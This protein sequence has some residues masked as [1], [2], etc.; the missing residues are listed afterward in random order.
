MSSNWS[1]E[2]PTTPPLAND[3]ASVATPWAPPNPPVPGPTP[4]LPPPSPRRGTGWRA[5]I[6]VVAIA[7]V[8]FAGFAFGRLTDGSDSSTEAN[9]SAADLPTDPPVG[10]V[11][12][13]PVLAIA[14]AVTPAVVKI[15]AGAG[16]G[17]GTV[18]DP[19]GLI[20]TNAHVVGDSSSVNVTYSD[21]S[22]TQGQV[23]GTDQQVDVAVVRVDPSTVLEVAVLSLDDD[24]QVGQIAVAIGTPFAY[25]QTV[26]AGIVSATDRP[27]VLSGGVSVPMVQTDAAI[28]SGNSGGALVDGQGRLIGMPTVIA[29][30]SGDS[31]GIGFAVPIDLAYAQAQKIVNGQTLEMP[32]LGVTG[33][34]VDDAR[35]PGAPISEVEQGSAASDAGLQPGDIVQAVDGRVT[36]S[37]GE[38]TRYVRT[39]SPGDAVE[40]E[41]ERDGSTLTVTA[42]LGTLS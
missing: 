37:F 29:T 3:Q 16:L 12:A 5:V 13:E 8:V 22:S 11:L 10:G 15:E 38:L 26:T 41:V 32:L 23:V 6:A 25:E 1:H 9:G 21:G 40:I 24:V 27:F 33:A 18:V 31:A 17:T 35:A 30:Q 2:A 34:E 28:N 20:L 14:E 4:S 7:A 19:D 42:T 36:D 39:Y